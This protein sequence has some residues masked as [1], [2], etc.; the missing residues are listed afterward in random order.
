VGKGARLE[1]LDVEF[2]KAATRLAGTWGP[3]LAGRLGGVPVEEG[4]GGTLKEKTQ[5]RKKRARR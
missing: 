4:S 1:D 2:T 5:G 3:D